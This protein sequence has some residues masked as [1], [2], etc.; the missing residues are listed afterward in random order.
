MA[1][2]EA[3]EEDILCIDSGYV[4]GQFAAIYL[5]RAGDEFA[6]IETGTQHTLDGVMT[7]LT[8]LGVAREQIKYVI[9]THIHLDHAGGAG[10]MMAEF[11]QATLVVHPRGARHLIDPKKLIEGSTQVYGEARFKQLYGEIKPVDENRVLIAN[12][13]DSICLGNRELLFIDTPGHARHHFCIV[14]QQSNGIFTGDTFGIAYPALKS[15]HRGL[16]PTTSPVQFDPIALSLS[17]DKLLT[18]QPKTMYLTHFGELQDPKRHG[19]S[20]KQWIDQF[21]DLCKRI[22]P[23]DAAS[24]QALHQALLQLVLDETSD[25]SSRQE[26]AGLLDIDLKLNAQGLAQWWQSMKTSR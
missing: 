3:L 22:A 23:D 25:D 4:R 5:L 13:L 24:E 10:H 18:Y 12:D 8:E 2:V 11:K 26:I 16:I 9:P 6:I 19:P 17:I 14:D 15:I 1:R 21:V 20:L 7:V